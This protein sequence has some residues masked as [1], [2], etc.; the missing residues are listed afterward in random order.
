[1][2]IRCPKGGLN[3]HD[4][5]PVRIEYIVKLYSKIHIFSLDAKLSKN[6]PLSREWS[7]NCKISQKRTLFLGYNDSER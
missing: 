6:F 2:A 4:D 7:K 1:M 5:Q 3:R